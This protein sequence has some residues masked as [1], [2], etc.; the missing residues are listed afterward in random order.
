M[1]AFMK[2]REVAKCFTLE[3]FACAHNN[4]H[5]SGLAIAGYDL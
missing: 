5:T 4:R 2:V 1:E 3:C